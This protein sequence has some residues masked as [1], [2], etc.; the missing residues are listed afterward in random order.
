MYCP[1]CDC[2]S[3]LRSYR[4]NPDFRDD[5]VPL[6]EEEEMLETL[7]RDVPKM[8]DSTKARAIRHLRIARENGV[9]SPWYQIAIF[10]RRNP[11]GSYP[12]E[13]G[14]TAYRDVRGA[15]TT[16]T[17]PRADSLVCK[18]SSSLAGGF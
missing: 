2:P 15:K 6:N 5:L 14:H 1:N 8:S 11:H 18:K 17:T 16:F 3:C 13:V 9:T 7:Q 10:H 4:H 12:Y